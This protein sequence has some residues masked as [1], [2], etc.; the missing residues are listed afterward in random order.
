MLPE[1]GSTLGLFAGSLE[2]M[3]INGVSEYILRKLP[4]WATSLLNP[5]KKIKGG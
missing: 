4:V 1:L 2:T 3:G 5:A